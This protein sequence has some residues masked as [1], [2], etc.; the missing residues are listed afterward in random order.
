MAGANPIPA[1]DAAEGASEPSPPKMPDVDSARTKLRQRWELASVL[2][3]LHVFHPIIGGDLKLSAEDVETAIIEQ[4]S[5]LAK[6]HIALLKGILPSSQVQTLKSS[7]AW[8]V[9]LSKA[10]S[11]WWPWVAEGDFPLTGAKGEEISIYKELEPTARV[12]ILKALCE[13]RADQYDVASYISEQIKHGTDLSY[14]RK[15]KL[16]SDGNRVAF[17]YDG[18]ETIGHRL[19]KEVNFF[20]KRQAKN[21][22]TVPAVNCQWETLA[23]NLEEFNKI[24]NEFSSSKF[25]WEVALGKSVEMDVIPVLAKQQKKKEK[26]LYRLQREQLLFNG[27]RNSVATRSCRSNKPV[28]YRFDNYDRAIAEAIK[29]SNKRKTSEERMQEEKPSQRRMTSTSDGSNSSAITSREGES[30][31][32][33]TET[34]NPE[35]RDDADGSTD[36]EYVE[37]EEDAIEKD[38][39]GDEQKV[40]RLKQNMPV[41]HKSKGSRFSKRL[42]GVPGYTIPES[43]TLGSKNTSRQRPSINTAAESVVIA[44]SEDES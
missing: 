44:D 3:F 11:T 7:D 29:V 12:V 32:T 43:M 9:A 21:K 36:E 2:N 20:E 22:D 19:Y 16:A 40:P 6:L 18:N 34:R 41:V 15:D 31:E 28:D 14:F 4:N 8:M 26:A 5:T 10:L 42:A 33:D 35:E 23:T 27:F 25:K 39:D 37:N 13:V 30:T 24:V 17:W 1:N 38:E